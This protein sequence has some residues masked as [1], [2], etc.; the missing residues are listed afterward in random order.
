MA[1]LMLTTKDN[2]YSP[3]DQFEQWWNY[4][5]ISGYHTCELLGSVASMTNAFQSDADYD[6]DVTIAMYKIVSLLPETYMVV[7]APEKETGGGGQ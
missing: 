5:F 1:D 4:D 7:E 3:F 2:P 6:E